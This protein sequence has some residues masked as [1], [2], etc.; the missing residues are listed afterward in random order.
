MKYTS[1]N[2]YVPTYKEWLAH[3]IF[4]NTVSSCTLIS[5]LPDTSSCSDYTGTSF[6]SQI[7]DVNY[8][9]LID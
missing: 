6:H 1:V 5:I 8:S 2:L 3:L 4:T 9:E 7:K